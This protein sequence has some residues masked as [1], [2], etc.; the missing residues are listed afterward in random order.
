MFSPVLTP[1]DYYRIDGALL[2]PANGA[3][4]AWDELKPLLAK[5]Q[6]PGCDATVQAP[7]GNMLGEFLRQT[8]WPEADIKVALDAERPVRLS[9][10]LG[11]AELYA[12]PWELASFAEQG[13]PLSVYENCLIRYAW[14]SK[15]GTRA[16]A[17]DPKAEGGRIL[18][19]WSGVDKHLSDA[20]Q[21]AIQRAAAAS[22]LPFNP[23][24]DVL[25]DVS[26]RAL[27]ERL[28]GASRDK[29]PFAALHILCHGRK[30]GE[31]G[32]AYGLEWRHHETRDRQVIDAVKLGGL[33]L[34]YA[35][36]LRLVVLCA[37][38]G[39][40]A[41]DPGNHVG[42]VAQGIH[43]AGIEAVV[44]SRFPL[45]VAGSKVLAREFYTHLLKDP[46]SVEAAFLAARRELAKED[47]EKDNLSLQLY[48]REEDGFD[49]RPIVFAPYRALDPFAPKHA[50]FFFGRDDEKQ[51]VL[52]EFYE[53]DRSPDRPRFQVVE[54]AS[55]SGKSSLVMAAV[56]PALV[57][58]G[59]TWARMV[60]E[61]D[62]DRALDVA[63][64]ARPADATRFLVVVDQFEEIFTRATDDA[65]G[66]A[67]AD[68][69]VRRLWELCRPEAGVHMICT[70]RT[71]FRG[72]CGEVHLNDAMRM[73]QLFRK[74]MAIHTVFVAQM[75]PAQ[76]RRV[77]A[78]PAA[79]VGLELP[80]DLVDRALDDVGAEPGA[81]PLLEYTLDLLWKHREGRR[82]SGD[83]YSKMGGVRGALCQ[84]AEKVY[85]GFSEAQQKAARRL[86][87]RLV[88]VR[89]NRALDTRRR[90]AVATLR[91]QSD[92]AAADFAF[93]LES[94]VKHRLLVQ[95]GDPTPTVEVA[96]EALIR[97]W[98]RIRGWVTEDR[99]MLAEREKIDRWVAEWQSDPARL[100]SPKQLKDAEEFQDPYGDGLSEA[101]HQLIDASEAAAE[102]RRNLVLDERISVLDPDFY[103]AQYP[104]V[105]PACNHE[106]A[107]IQ[108]HWV[109]WGIPQ[110]R[111]SSAD[112]SVRDY[113]NNYPDLV[114]AFGDTN[115][116]AALTHWFHHGKKEG[117]YGG[118][119]PLPGGPR[120]QVLD[121]DFYL[122]NQPDLIASG[123]T[124]A[125]EDVIRS[126]WLT[127]GLAEG[128][129]SS[130]TFCI[131]DYVESEPA[132]KERFESDYAA[133]LDHWIA[134]TSP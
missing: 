22:D 44:A 30:L 50:R 125:H 42:G 65:D 57:E 120:L 126:H 102:A 6:A 121:L 89:G 66:R 107:A 55:G 60:P 24:E 132:L 86:L 18:F 53:L 43:R 45:S 94:L 127:I 124:R 23:E 133:A 68:R 79:L 74:E 85:A 58:D 109:M 12:L 15:T 112:F 134:T 100:L 31:E 2:R 16:L 51:E 128:R 81:L 101:A 118:P 40:D 29:Q 25:A 88:D 90:E 76:L 62:P 105:G 84:E 64:A 8:D 48:A 75:A 92:A 21:E 116:T 87:V 39:G 67:R 110:G 27:G 95:A 103:C 56:V 123:V 36:T 71:D 131:K 77:I 28:E 20:H 129:R 54:G 78:E 38:H 61:T 83:M 7:L 33:L 1:Q 111:Q 98:E 59:W 73:D 113:L 5:L 14:P 9:V 19:A 96:H 3:R 99:V 35:S 69:F 47:D 17:R 49:T 11:A 80:Q 91:P 26:F 63:L 114:A 70:M 82:L 4:I 13:Q 97:T 93:V 130:A 106:V 122:M 104:E 41:G 115:Y 119:G 32:E 37:C 52:R 117:R 34:K 108:R 72:R 10:K 46:T